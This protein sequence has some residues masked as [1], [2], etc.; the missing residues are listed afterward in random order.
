[1]YN[2]G[3]PFSEVL[4]L[5]FQD[6]DKRVERKKASLILV[7]GGV[8]EGKTTLLIEGIDYFNK[9]H[10]LPEYDIKSG[11]QLAMGGADFLKKLE[12]CFELGLPVIAY[13]EA[14]DFNRR[15]SLTRFNAMINR[16]FET[17]RAFKIVVILGLPNFAVL[18]QQLFDNQIPRLL[19]HLYNRTE[20]QGNFKGYSLYGMLQMKSAMRKLVVKPYA[21][22]LITPNFVGHFLDLEP[23]RS[24]TLD[25]ISIKSKID[26]LRKSEAKIEGL[27]SY[28]ELAHKLNRSLIWVKKSV[29]K[30]EIKHDKIISRAKYFTE[31]DLNRLIELIED[32]PEGRPPGS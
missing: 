5:N 8:G 2:Y 25:K 15:G 32:T 9:L 31:N 17:F 19:L 18:D 11:Y 30:L 10:G 1:M 24:K 22:K 14:G 20:N 3:L 6:L 26:I 16:T 21:Y 7:D 12:K 13:D 27:L 28:S 29:K 23:S 4:G